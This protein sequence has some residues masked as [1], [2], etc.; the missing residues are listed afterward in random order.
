MTSLM[1]ATILSAT[2]AWSGLL[3]TG[4]FASPHLA[5]HSSNR[6]SSTDLSASGRHHWH[7]HGPHY[8]GHPGRHG[9]PHRQ[10]YIPPT[11]YYSQDFPP[12]YYANPY[13]AP[14][15]GFVGGAG[16]SHLGYHGSF[17]GHDTGHYGYFGHGN[18]LGIHH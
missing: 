8:Y 5:L 13:Y 2:I 15:L 11:A 17:F 12:R 3:S 7:R 1:G 6:A 9:H 18:G 14:S 10:Q 16:H 4:T